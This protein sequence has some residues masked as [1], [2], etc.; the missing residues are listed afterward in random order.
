MRYVFMVENR[1]GDTWTDR[2]PTKWAICAIFLGESD[3]RGVV[4]LLARQVTQSVLQALEFSPVTLVEGPRQ[5]GKSV[6]VRDLVG[7]D[8]PASY[9]TLDDLISLSSAR[10][11]SQGFVMGLPDPVVI[12]EVQ[13]A[14]EIFLALKLSVDQDRRPGRFLL[15]GS[16][17]VLLLPQLS[18]SL[19]GRMRIITLWPLSQGEID[20][21]AGQFIGA[22]FADGSLPHYQGESTRADIADRITRGGFPQ[23]VALPVG[24]ARDGWMRDYVTTL[25]ERDVRELAAIS[26]RV[27]LPRLLK[28][29]AVRS[30]TL[31][32]VSDLARATGIARATLDRYLALFVKTFAIQFVSPWAG[33][34]ARRPVRSP[35]VLF[36][37]SGL[38]AYLSGL[39]SARLLEDPDQLGSML[40]T[41]VGG[42]LLKQLSA[43]PDR[44]E[45]MHYRD[46]RGTEVDWVL[47][48]SRGRVVGIEVKATASPSSR[49]FNG[50]RAFAAAV[51]KRFHRGIVL[52]TGTTAAPMGDGMWALPVDALW[53]LKP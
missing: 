19:A 50:L 38:A 45:L 44:F 33:D 48:D 5:A 47:E 36:A 8:R 23:A 46:S 31:L 9:V 30:G 39:D 25:L 11:D 2:F 52:H 29:L 12:D 51:G 35:K 18:D 37:D 34:I 24:P 4:M 16:A 6:L 13:R 28:I 20:G 21:L 27:A 22:V 42:E 7:A 49:D 53:R 43:L 41:F 1:L 10:E 17:N 40:E 15:T 32:N 3:L 26:D 14:P